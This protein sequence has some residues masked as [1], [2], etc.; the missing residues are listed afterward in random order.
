[1]TNF[2][3]SCPTALSLAD[4]KQ[5]SKTDKEINLVR[6]GLYNNHWIQDV[7]SYR[8]FESELCFEDKILLRGHKIVIPEA[9]RSRVLEAAHEGHPGIVSM[10]AR[11]RTKVWGPKIDREAENFVKCCKGCTLVSAPNLPHP[12]KRRSLPTKAWTEVAIDY[13]GPLPSKHY[14]FVIVDYFSRYKE[15]KVMTSITASETIK[16]LK[17]IFSRLGTPWSIT[18]DNAKQLKDCREF[19]ASCLEYDI[20]LEHTIPYWPQMNGEVERQNRDILKRLKISQLQKPDWKDD[21]FKYLM[22]YNSTPHSTTEKSP[23]EL[24]YN[25]LFRDELPSAMNIENDRVMVDLEV[26]D[27]D[28]EMKMKGSEYGDRKRRAKENDLRI[29]EKVYVQ[30]DETGLQQRRNVVHLKRVE[31]KWTVCEKENQENHN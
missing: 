3:S 24:F 2:E 26:Q 9:L 7:N 21:L 19:D 31:G 11:L 6:E 4:I 18:A 12:M 8:I 5:A 1:M 17:E 22:M 30:N 27:K 25:R 15:I 20:H 23:S 10:K 13:L 14:L 28:F 16:V 29:G